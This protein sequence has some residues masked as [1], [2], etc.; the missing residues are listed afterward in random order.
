[1]LV[2][3]EFPMFGGRVACDA[4]Y[5]CD[6]N[7]VYFQ[8]WAFMIKT[9]RN[10]PAV[11]DYTMT[12]EGPLLNHQFAMELYSLAKALDPMRPVS[13]SDGIGDDGTSNHS[14]PT[15]P[16]PAVVNNSAHGNPYDFLTPGYEGG[17]MPLDNPH[18]FRPGNVSSFPYPQG[19]EYFG[20]P[21]IN[22]ETG[23]IAT[24]PD[25]GQMENFEGGATKPFW[26]SPVRDKLQAN[27]LLNESRM[28][29]ERSNK[30]Y[31]FAWKD[32]M[33]AIRKTVQLS[34]YEWWLLQV[35]LST[36]GQPALFLTGRVS[37]IL[38]RFVAIRSLFS[39]SWRQES[40]KRH[41]R[42]GA[43]SPPFL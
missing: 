1:M 31:V 21:L 35:R 32:R 2:Q 39:P 24:F 26:L 25:L 43:R 40:G 19:F 4:S 23:N 34:G 37:P 3:A 22:H 33:E 7:A 29:H 18:L 28:W 42:T 36:E 38:A 6:K 10:F 14:N 17:A 8:D 20:Q 12:N 11:F 9:L 41:Q 13:T 15:G 16:H 30:M 27:G 5:A